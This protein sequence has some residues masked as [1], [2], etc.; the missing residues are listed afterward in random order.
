MIK[1]HDQKTVWKE[2]VYLVY[3]SILLLITEGQDKN[4]NLE[5]GAD[6]EAVEWCPLLGLPP[7]LFI[8]LPNT[9]YDHQLGIS[10]SR[11]SWVLPDQQGHSETNR[12]YETNGP[13]RYL[14]NILS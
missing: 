12:S 7:S 9:P 10:L 8:L 13:D 2:K 11:R 14:Q 1:H 6:V 3:V 4:R 5:V